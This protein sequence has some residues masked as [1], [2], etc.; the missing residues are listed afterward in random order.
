[1]RDAD[2]PIGIFDSGVG[3]ISVLSQVRA[4]LPAEHLLYYGDNA[5]APYGT[6]SPEQVLERTWAVTRHLLESGAKAL[7][8]ACNTATSVAAPSLREALAMPVVGMEPA[9]KAASAYRHGGSVLVL[10]T[11]VTLALPK[12]AALMARYGEGAVPLPCAGLMEFAER[13]ELTGGALYAHLAALL[14][15]WPRRAVDAVVLGCTHYIYLR[16]V[17]AS[18]FAPGTPI[19]DG[20][21]GT[22]R[23]L[24]RLLEERALLCGEE[25]QG[26]VTL[27]TSGAQERVLPVM[28]RL[29][30][31]GVPE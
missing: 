31:V 11:P 1:M 30:A 29:L 3:G 5:W 22:A 12:F 21:L 9:L 23:Q 25:R 17:I 20:N 2:R 10:A 24:A 18:F 28:R 6:R 4:L 8:I 13:G 26:T 27:E 14:G 7:L 15:E 16:P 19:V